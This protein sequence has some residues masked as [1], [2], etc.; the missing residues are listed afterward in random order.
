M[1]KED[2]QMQA[3]SALPSA[4]TPAWAGKGLVLSHAAMDFEDTETPGLRVRVLRTAAE[5]QAIAHLRRHAAFG[6]ENDLGLG[7]QPFEQRRDDIGHVVAVYR[8]ERL[9]ASARAVPTGHGLTAA[10]R[11]FAKVPFDAS[12]LGRGSWEIGRMI[13]EPEDRHPELLHECLIV[14]L[15][16]VMQTE[17]VRHFHA[18]STPAMARLWRRIGMRSVV[19]ATGA[20]GARYSLVHACVEDLMAAL[21]MPH[22]VDERPEPAPPRVVHR[23]PAGLVA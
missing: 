20:S 8:G 11:L 16:E 9:V 14:C 13:M 21:H 5:R 3:V 12:I 1:F 22:Y 19:T 7:L 17:D 18:T 15:E 23:A 6:V 10:E 2:F 4:G